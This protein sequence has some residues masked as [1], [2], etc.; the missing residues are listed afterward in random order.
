M[1]ET[2]R[3]HFCLKLIDIGVD[4]AKASLRIVLI[5]M[6]TRSQIVARRL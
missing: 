1:F 4:F 3:R 6:P 2:Q 5:I